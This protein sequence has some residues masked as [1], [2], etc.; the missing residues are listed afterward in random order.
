VKEWCLLLLSQPTLYRAFSFDSFFPPKLGGLTDVSQ[1][2]N[3]ERHEHPEQTKT[4]SS[5]HSWK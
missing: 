1:V 5:N 3:P 2:F 4:C